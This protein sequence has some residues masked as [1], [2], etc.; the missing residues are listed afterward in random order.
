M[1]FSRW[2][3]EPG[4][5]ADVRAS[6]TS[7]RRGAPRAD[8]W[9]R[10]DAVHASSSEITRTAS[11]DTIT[12]TWTYDAAGRLATAS[13]GLDPSVYAYDAQ[14]HLVSVRR[15]QHPP[16]RLTYDERGWLLSQGRAWRAQRVRDIRVVEQVE[17]RVAFPTH[18][19][20]LDGRRRSPVFRAMT[21]WGGSRLPTV[22]WLR[23]VRSRLARG[24]APAPPEA[25]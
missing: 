17:D 22:R 19:S 8:G 5:R 3:R 1:S 21:H 25:R 9:G 6:V 15:G 23:S 14:G 20:I 12:Y 2:W 24:P 10:G 18:A 7:P 4:V 13:D 16:A 11:G